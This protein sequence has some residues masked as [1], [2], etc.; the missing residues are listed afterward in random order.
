MA[1][2]KEETA[3]TS[4]DDVLPA[5]VDDEV[6]DQVV[7][8]I[9][10]VTRASLF[11]MA[12]N[13]GKIIVDNFYGGELAAWR[14][15][16][17]KD[18][19]FRKLAERRDCDLS[20]ANLFRAV[21]V[22]EMCD[23]IGVTKWKHLQV[24]HFYAVIGLKE[25]DQRRLLEQAEKKGWQVQAVEKKAKAI[26]AKAAGKRG[27]P[28]LP[29]FVKTINRFSKM[30]ADDSEAF[31]ELEKVEELDEDDAEKLHQAVIGMKLKCEELQQK[32]QSR[33]PGFGSSDD[34]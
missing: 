4:P 9:N 5:P 21:S 10:E 29:A 11:E 2:E 18:A 28:A 3:L 15:R 6:I 30:L 16:G 22:Y 13:V 26:R 1:D 23:K 24:G 27:R 17:K 32:L 20:A 14:D 12:L 19:S 7:A 25:K 33:M 31:G 8:D 34:E